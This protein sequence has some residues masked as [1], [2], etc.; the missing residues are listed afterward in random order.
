[1]EIV[2]KKLTTADCH[3]DMLNGFERTQV[4]TKAWVQ[5][6]GVWAIEDVCE[7]E[8]WD[9]GRLKEKSSEFADCIKSGGVVICAYRGESIVGLAYLLPRRFGDNA[10]YIQLRSLHVSG[11]CRNHG[12][13]KRLFSAIADEARAM[14]AKKMYISANPSVDTI[15]FYHRVGCVDAVFIEQSIYLDTPED[16]Q[17]EY[18]L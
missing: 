5:T 11:S 17:M 4:I 7:T 3:A 15:A 10:E 12:V 16:R 18:V 13:G 6:D 2:L 8:D 1:M 9:E 14:D